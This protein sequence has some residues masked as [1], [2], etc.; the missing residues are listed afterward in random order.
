MSTNKKTAAATYVARF[1]KLPRSTLCSFHCCRHQ[2]KVGPGLEESRSKT[3][4]EG[5]E[6][7]PIQLGDLTIDSLFRITT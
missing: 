1:T 4:D 6:E 3:A 2:Q 5:D 7:G